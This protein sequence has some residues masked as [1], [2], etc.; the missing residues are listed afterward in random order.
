MKKM[1]C[2]PAMLLLAAAV[3][4]AAWSAGTLEEVKKKGVLVVGVNEATPPFGFLDHDK[5]EIVGI[6]PDLA[7]ALAKK[8]DVRLKLLPVSSAGRIPAILDGKVDIVAATMSKNP[9]RARLV[10]FSLTYFKTAERLLARTGAIVTVKDLAGKKVGVVQGSESEHH[11]KREA[12][13]AAIYPFS[14]YKYAVEALRKGSIDAMAGDG[15]ILYAILATL[16]KDAFEVPMGISLADKSYGMAVRKGDAKFIEFVDA[17]LTEVNRCGEGK[18]IIEKWLQRRGAAVSPPRATEA[19]GGVVIRTT[20]TDGRFVVLGMSGVFKCDSEVGIFDP[21]GN[22]VCTGKVLSIYGDELYV[23]ASCA[24]KD[25]IEVGSPVSC[26]YGSLDEAK[27]L[28]LE[29]KEVLKQVKEEAKKESEARQKEIAVQYTKEE[30]ERHKSQEQ[31][32]STKMQLDYQYNDEQYY[33][34]RWGLGGYGGGYYW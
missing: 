24:P 2:V 34:G 10:D 9:D 28:I 4:T 11:L 18:I 14:A 22:F 33:W 20:S 27:R 17:T 21:Q 12:P 30:A 25:S 15:V 23:D 8:L 13:A 6:E 26:G 7:A 32:E 1:L 3:S 16:P 19:A 31:F 5:G 29:R